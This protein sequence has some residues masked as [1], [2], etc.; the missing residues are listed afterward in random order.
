M[1]GFGKAVQQQHQRRTW[2]AG[3]EG[4]EGEAGREGDFFESGH[5]DDSA[6]M[7]MIQ[8]RELKNTPSTFLGTCGT[9]QKYST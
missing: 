4:V 6:G 1:H 3:D 5:G 9:S 2:L 7:E 8:M